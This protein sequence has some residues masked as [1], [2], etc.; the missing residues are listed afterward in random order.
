MAVRDHPGTPGALAAPPAAGGYHAGLVGVIEDPVRVF[1]DPVGP[2]Q[3]LVSPGQGPVRIN[4]RGI[5]AG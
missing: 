3:G 5:A 2:G 1:Q 4:G